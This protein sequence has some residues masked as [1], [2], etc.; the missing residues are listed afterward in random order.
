LGHLHVQARL[1]E[2]LAYTVKKHLERI[3]GE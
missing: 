3:P 1:N 2:D